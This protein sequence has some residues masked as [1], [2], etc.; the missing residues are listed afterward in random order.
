MSL[1]VWISVKPCLSKCPRKSSH[2]PDCILIGTGSEADMCIQAAKVLE[3]EGKKVRVVSMPCTELFEAQ[4]ADYKES[5][6]PAACSTRVSVEAGSTFGW[7]KYVGNT[8]ASVG[9]D[10]FGASA[11]ANILYEKYGVTV[12]AVVQAAKGQM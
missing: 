8:G 3:G 4:S 10:D 6:L 12:D 1:G 11:P 9:V 7:G 5:I 2:T